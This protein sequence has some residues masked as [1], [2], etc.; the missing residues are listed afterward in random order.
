MKN[1]LLFL[2]F[3]YSPYTIPTDNGMSKSFRFLTLINFQDDN[4]KNHL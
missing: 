3:C 4:L 2:A 1:Q